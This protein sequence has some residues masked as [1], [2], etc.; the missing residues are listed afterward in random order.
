[1]RTLPLAEAKAHLSGVL[2]ELARTSEPVTITRHGKPAAVIVTPEEVESINLTMEWLA[3]PDH[4]AEMTEAHESVAAGT[5]TSLDA[6]REE[7]DAI[8]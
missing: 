4:A 8:R 2:D 3:D 1:M 5:G 6:M 7:L